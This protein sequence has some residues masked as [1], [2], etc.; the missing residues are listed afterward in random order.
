MA[1]TQKLQ[2]G[3]SSQ[4]V[5]GGGGSVS[6]FSPFMFGGGVDGALTLVANAAFAQYEWAHEYA[7]AATITLPDKPVVIDGCGAATITVEVN[8]VPTLISVALGVGVSVGGDTVNSVA[9]VAG[10][11]V[12]VSRASVAGQV[13]SYVLSLGLA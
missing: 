3:R 12:E 6:G 2:T 5:D 9:V 8:G 7:L 4:F 10:D 13:D 1:N 11:I